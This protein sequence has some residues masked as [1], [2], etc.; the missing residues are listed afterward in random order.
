MNK[1]SGFMGYKSIFA[2]RLRE[3][4]VKTLPCGYCIIQY[5][6]EAFYMTGSSSPVNGSVSVGIWL[7]KAQNPLEIIYVILKLPALERRPR[8]FAVLYSTQQLEPVIPTIAVYPTRGLF[9]PVPPVVNSESLV[10]FF[11]E[12]QK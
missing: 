8:C 3:L 9:I 5:H 11:I 12:T 1:E 2:V 10:H 7:Y 4:M 6:G